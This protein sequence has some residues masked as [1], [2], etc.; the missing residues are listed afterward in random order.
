MG[1]GLSVFVGLYFCEVESVSV[2]E[3]MIPMRKLL[4]KLLMRF[5][6]RT[7]VRLHNHELRHC[8][9]SGYCVVGVTRAAI[10]V[11]V[12]RL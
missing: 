11:T 8:T 4:E 3:E 9:L 1:W 5:R 12:G 10:S 7:M 6:Y 2:Y